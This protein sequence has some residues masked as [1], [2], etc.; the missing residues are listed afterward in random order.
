MAKCDHKDAAITEEYVV[1]VMH[2]HD[3]RTG[4]WTSRRIE[5]AAPKNISVLCWRCGLS[6]NY[7]T[8][9]PK[10]LKERMKEMHEPG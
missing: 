3:W 8:R 5:G 10:W 7:R 2:T 4:E 9:I 6:R 1:A